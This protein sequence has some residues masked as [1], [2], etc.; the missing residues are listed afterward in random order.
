MRNDLAAVILHI[1]LSFFISPNRQKNC[2]N[3]CSF[4]CFYGYYLTKKFIKGFIS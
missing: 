2:E 3:L 4:C 1:R